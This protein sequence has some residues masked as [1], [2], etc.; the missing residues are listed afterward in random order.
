MAVKLIEAG[1][2]AIIL[3][4]SYDNTGE[5]VTATR[6]LYEF[7]RGFP[8][9]VSGLCGLDAVL[10]EHSDAFDADQF[11]KA[12]EA[13]KTVVKHQAKSAPLRVP[14]CY[15]KPFAKDI[16]SVTNTTG[17][18]KAELIALHQSLTYEVWMVGFMPGFPYMGELPKRLQLERKATPDPLIPGGSVAI[19]EEYVG[20]YPFDSPGGWHVIGRTPWVIIDYSKSRPSLFEAGMRVQFY[21]ISEEEFRKNTKAPGHKD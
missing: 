7:A 16:D 21:A 1:E 11:L 17:M 10:L 6:A 12:I 8:G 9:I 3:S 5:A 19:A 13:K 15:E 2:S 4:L 18:A 20:I 14:I